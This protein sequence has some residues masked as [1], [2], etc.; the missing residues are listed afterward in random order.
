MNQIANGWHKL[1]GDG[2]GPEDAKLGLRQMGSLRGA[3]FV[4][5]W[6]NQPVNW[7]WDSGQTADIAEAFKKYN[8]MKETDQ[9]PAS[10]L[11]ETSALTKHQETWGKTA[12]ELLTETS[13]IPSPPEPWNSTP[14]L[15]G[16]LGLLVFGAVGKKLAER[17]MNGGKVRKVALER[18]TMAV[19]AKAQAPHV[20]SAR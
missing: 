19:D 17:R 20:Q 9:T 12:L 8:W 2:L 11:P 6:D 3:I 14:V 10:P 5:F 16:A 15:V 18:T 13:A 4:K 1:P 7:T